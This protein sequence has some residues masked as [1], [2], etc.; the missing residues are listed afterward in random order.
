MSE[1]LDYSWVGEIASE[2]DEMAEYLSGTT[3][4]GKERIESVEY[5]VNNALESPE[6]FREQEG[7]LTDAESIQD[8]T[9]HI[10][11]F[12]LGTLT[13]KGPSDYPTTTYQL[14]LIATEGGSKYWEF[15]SVDADTELDAQNNYIKNLEEKIDDK[16][17]D[18]PTEIKRIT[19]EYQSSS[20]FIESKL[21]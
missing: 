10:S 17:E 20:S 11:E 8:I 6:K 9:K 21:S 7:L 2:V 14:D 4:D 18:E 5:G 13:V 15:S 16:L 19:E 3:K 12:P 1:D